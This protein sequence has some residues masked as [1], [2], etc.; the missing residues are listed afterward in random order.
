MNIITQ[1]F[2]RDNFPFSPERESKPIYIEDDAHYYQYDEDGRLSLQIRRRSNSR[3]L[4][5]FYDI[6]NRFFI[7]GEVTREDG[8]EKSLL[9]LVINAQGQEKVIRLHRSHMISSARNLPQ[10]V[11]ALIDA[12]IDFGP[13]PKAPTFLLRFL[14]LCQPSRHFTLCTSTGWTETADAFVFPGKIIT[15]PQSEKLIYT[16]IEIQDP[17]SFS[18]CGSLDDWKQN[19]CLPCM[20][21]TRLSLSL[22][23]AFAAP[24]LPF[25]QIPESGGIHIFGKSSI[26]KSL[27]GTV[28]NSVFGYPKLLVNQWK[29]TEAGLESTAVQRNH[30]P[31]VLDELGQADPEKLSDQIYFLG[32]GSAKIRGTLT[33]VPAYRARWHCLPLSNG[34]ISLPLLAQIQRKYDFIEGQEVRLTEIPADVGNGSI[35]ETLPPELANCTALLRSIGRSSNKFYGV[36]G[37]VWIRALTHLDKPALTKDFQAFYDMHCDQFSQGNNAIASR[38]GIR[39]AL[40]AFAGELASKH[41]ITGWQAGFA[42]R[43]S[44]ACFDDW[45]MFISAFID[46]HHATVTAFISAIET[47]EAGFSRN[48]ETLNDDEFG[49]FTQDR[50]IIPTTRFSSLWTSL[51]NKNPVFMKED[52]NSFLR[53]MKRLNTM[54]TDGRHTAIKLSPRKQTLSAETRAYVFYLDKLKAV[55]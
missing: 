20:H 21:S 39:F 31:L 55:A 35:C 42:T 18:S 48:E 29:A 12:G 7:L 22:C 16:E 44:K 27:C 24:L 5:E 45:Y 1:K 38:V 32:N 2:N 51:K 3:E 52:E 17:A 47:P 46:P 33:G 23:L 13:H 30:L 9:L 11:T 4:P 14:R 10:L 6:A 8:S 49:W 34:E 37:D 41:E 53:K 43:V 26:G 25:A 50:I 36:A 28:A 40:M 54:Q 19:V 15:A